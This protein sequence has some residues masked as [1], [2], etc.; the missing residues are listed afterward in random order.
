MQGIQGSRQHVWRPV[1]VS[2]IH[3]SRSPYVFP[4]F[5]DFFWIFN[6]TLEN[7]YNFVILLLVTVGHSVFFNLSNFTG[8][9]LYHFDFPGQ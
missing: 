7:L 3:P 6:Y 2:Q 4:I 1:L 9:F 8:C 5:L